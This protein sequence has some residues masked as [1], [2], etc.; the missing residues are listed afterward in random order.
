M[1]EQPR[2]HCAKRNYVWL[3]VI[4]SFVIIS[5]I[6]FATAYFGQQ[7]YRNNQR[8][9]RTLIDEFTGSYTTVPLLIILYFINRRIP[10]NRKRLALKLLFYALL[11][12]A[13]G[14][15]HTTLMTITRNFIYSWMKD[16]GQY[17]MGNPFDRYAFEMTKQ[18]K[19][20]FFVTGL[21][22]WL[23]YYRTSQQEKLLKAE[24]ER[25]LVQT[26]LDALKQQLNPHFLFNTLNL[27]SVKAYEDPSMADLLITQLSD[28]LRMSLELG[29]GQTIPLKQELQFTRDYVHIML[30]RFEKRISFSI[31]Q[32]EN[33]ND[34]LVPSLILQ[35][36][37]ENA[38][39]HGLDDSNLPIE[40]RIRVNIEVDKLKLNITNSI[41]NPQ[42]TASPFSTGLGIRNIQERLE[43]LYP[44]QH[45]L[46]YGKTDTEHFRFAIT[47]PL[48]RNSASIQV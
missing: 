31:E 16:F 40:I 29:K 48:E 45:Q 3:F 8:V 24:L 4:V 15:A 2:V 11:F 14:I 10:I 39:K 22:E 21:F 38:I 47:L 27:I 5:L 19:A 43:T 34:V 7:M 41:L 33:S 1:H 23:R 20:F 6:T 32:D 30:A 17:N 28:L 18:I 12:L 26:R 36:T 25:K 46:L 35:P 37:V 13:L 42:Q 44:N 9:L